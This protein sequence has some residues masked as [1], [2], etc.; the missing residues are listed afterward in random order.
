MR[1]VETVQSRA[2]RDFLRS[3]RSGKQ[4]V[5]DPTDVEMEL[6]NI[7]EAADQVGGHPETLRRWDRNGY[8]KA[9]RRVGVKGV[10]FYSMFDIDAFMEKYVRFPTPT[11]DELGGKD[12]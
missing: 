10:R 6:L 2:G 1:I 8:F 7:N 4:A 5:G 3:L 11:P 12:D 9:T